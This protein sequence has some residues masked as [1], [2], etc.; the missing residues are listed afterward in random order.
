MRIEGEVGEGRGDGWG[1]FLIA[2]MGGGGV[3]GVQASFFLARGLV[4]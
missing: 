2:F 4:L 1:A 3:G